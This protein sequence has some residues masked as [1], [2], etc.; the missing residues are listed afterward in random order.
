MDGM[1]MDAD[2]EAAIQMLSDEANLAVE[3]TRLFLIV[4]MGGDQNSVESLP[5]KSP[6][7]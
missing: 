4:M 2:A 5:L 7:K 6:V 3:I 1:R